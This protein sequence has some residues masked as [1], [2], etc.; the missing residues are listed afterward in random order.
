MKNIF[1]ITMLA[2]LTFGL[3][4]QDKKND[5]LKIK[6]NK[7]RIWVFDDSKNLHDTINNKEKVKKADFTHWSGIDIGVNMLTTLDNKFSIMEANDTLQMNMFLDLNYSKSIFISLNLWEKSIALYKNNLILLTGIGSEWN[8]YNFKQNIT[9]NTNADYISAS[10]TLIN[11][12]TNYQKNKLKIWYVK[13]PLLLE[14]NTNNKKYKKSFHVSGGFE[15][16]YKLGSKT[17]QMYEADK[18]EYKI[19]TK[20]DFHLADFKY[21]TV[22]RIGYGNYFTVFANYA[23]SSLFEKNKGPDIYPFTTG[24]T[25]SF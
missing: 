25:F 22:M 8:S 9:L 1:L 12:K 5:T 6:W 24:L 7:S 21:S 18:V 10:N 17:K 4:A 2:L 15:F 13:V 14:L 16:A 19:K 20:D 11:I 23:L 3:R